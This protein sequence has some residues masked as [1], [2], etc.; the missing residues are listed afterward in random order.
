MSS[1]LVTGGAGFTG[2]HIVNEL[3]DAGHTTISFNRDF[4][5]APRPDVVSVQGELFD[6]P[7][8][9]EI[10]KEHDVDTIVHTAAI[11]HPTYSLSFPLATF[12][13]NV[14]G[15]VA[16]FE[17]ARIHGIKRIINFSSE[18]VYGKTSASVVLESEPVNPTTPYA[19]TKVTGEWLGQVYSD[20][21]GIDVISLRISQVYGP[22]NRM[23]EVMRDIM[24]GVVRDG[25]FSQDHGADHRYNLVYV[26]DVA[27]AIL[28]AVQAPQPAS[29]RPLAY[30]ISGGEYW[31]LSDV[32]KE[33]R[34]A[35]P[36]VSVEIG[37][38][39][40][41]TLD[42]QG[43]FSV[44]SAAGELGYEPAWPLQRAIGDYA[45]WLSTHD[46]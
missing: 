8:L 4:L 43:H 22:G 1:V 23:D 7:R 45:D 36:D 9:L 12:A 19:V 2:R 3:A 24:R 15:T 27:R 41:P 31:T 16:V 46:F 25:S 30:N 42:L 40:D 14:E 33:L 34:I 32:V 6:I 18:C 39:S 10:F 35:F 37:P 29:A 26:R 13:A 11:S 17:A 28:A 38:G 21:Y 20:R 5:D 44:A